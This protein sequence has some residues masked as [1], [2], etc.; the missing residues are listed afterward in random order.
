MNLLT[1]LA[2]ACEM[3]YVCVC[4]YVRCDAAVMEL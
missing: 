3:P 2:L 4:V 1:W